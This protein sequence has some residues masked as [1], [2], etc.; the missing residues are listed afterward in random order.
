[1]IVQ[2]HSCNADLESFGNDTVRQY[3][4]YMKE[5]Y[6]YFWRHSL[7]HSK[8]LEFYKVSKDEYSTSEYLVHQL[9]NFNEKRI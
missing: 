2:Y 6:I 4:T 8:I 3:S 9:R 5:K 1:M 7:E